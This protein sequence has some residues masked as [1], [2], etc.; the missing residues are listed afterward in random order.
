MK[1]YKNV[2]CVQKIKC[3]KVC[4]LLPENKVRFARAEQYDFEKLLLVKEYWQR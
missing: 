3:V 4:A 2:K 1:T